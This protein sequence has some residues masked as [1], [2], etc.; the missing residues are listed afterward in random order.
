MSKKRTTSSER[1]LRRKIEALKAQ[2]KSDTI[3]QQAKAI[4]S[5]PTLDQEV[6]S[7]DNTSL[8]RKDLLKT[9]LL[10]LVSFSV[11]LSVWIIR[12]S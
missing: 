10:S 2:L 6:V 5:T 1:E 4:K 7:I 12:N 3:P 9:I 11:I 8:I